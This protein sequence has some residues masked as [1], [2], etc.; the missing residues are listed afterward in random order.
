MEIILLF[1]ENQKLTAVTDFKDINIL[2]TKIIQTYTGVLVA[3]LSPNL[4][5]GFIII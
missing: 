1:P 3:N 2:F 4:P 5:V